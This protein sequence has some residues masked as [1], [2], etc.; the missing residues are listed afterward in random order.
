MS[1]EP[2]NN[3]DLEPGW[4]GLAILLWPVQAFLQVKVWIHNFL[5]PDDPQHVE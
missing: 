2:K 5:H 4:G 1:D 3:D